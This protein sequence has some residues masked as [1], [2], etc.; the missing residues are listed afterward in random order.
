VAKSLAVARSAQRGGLLRRTSAIHRLGNLTLVT[1]KLNPALSNKNWEYKRPAIQK[2]S[3]LRLTTG[4]VLS[5][6]EGDNGSE[7]ESW[8]TQRD[9]SRIIARTRHLT[10]LALEAWQRPA[11]TQANLQL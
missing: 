8:S 11:M 2:H 4:S 5:K 3:L 6:P 9:E 1:T 10:E 7:E